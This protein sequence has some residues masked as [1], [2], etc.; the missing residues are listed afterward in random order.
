MRAEYAEAKANLAKELPQQ[1]VVRFYSR[2]DT[3]IAAA[4][5]SATVKP[6]CQSGCAYC[7]YYKVEATAAEVLAIRHFAVSRFTPEQLQCTVQQAS[8]NVEEAKGFSYAE[9][10]MTNQACPFLVNNACSVYSVRP[11]KCRIFHATDV[12]GCK[13]SYERPDVPVPETYVPEVLAAA[14]ATAHAFGFAVGEAGF[15]AR[16]YD[17]NSAFLE[18]MHTSSA[19]KRL[20]GRKRVFL[21][22][23]VVLNPGEGA[24]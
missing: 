13:S 14:S 7:C 24:F 5:A 18:A 20:N 11:S 15:D 3:V 21:K 16:T 19:Q 12:E 4:I 9:H 1:A 8:R 6:A 17:L 2:Q 10:L 22:A 23:K